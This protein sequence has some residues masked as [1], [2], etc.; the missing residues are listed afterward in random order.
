MR[1]AD[2]IVF[3]EKGYEMKAVLHARSLRRNGNIIE[4]AAFSDIE[5]VKKY[6]EE[7]KIQKI[8]S[9]GETVSEL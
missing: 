2:A 9:V 5:K 7:L 6:A 3:A 8:I 4:M 1:K